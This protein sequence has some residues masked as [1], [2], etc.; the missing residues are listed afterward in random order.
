MIP[1]VAATTVEFPVGTTSSYAPVWITNAGTA[2]AFAVSVAPDAGTSVPRVELNWAVTEGTPGGSD[3]TVQFGWMGS[4]ESAAFAAD[5]A[6]NAMIYDLLDTTE[7]GSGDY[8]AQLA[9]E[10]YTLARGGFTSFS[11]FAVGNFSGG[12]VSVADAEEVPRVF[13]LEQNYPNPFNPSTEIRYDIPSAARVT[14]TIYDALGR[15]VSQLVDSEHVPGFYK[16]QWDASGKASGVYYY[17]IVAGD[18]VSVKKMMLV[19]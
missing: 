16:V 4:V 19:R 7:A 3:A 15:R 2:D 11:P 6:A 8:T 5:R 17:R 13:A 12:T 10:P 9:S 14:I 18:F 1:D